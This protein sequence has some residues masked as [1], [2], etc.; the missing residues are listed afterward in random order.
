MDLRLENNLGSSAVPESSRD[1]VSIEV[2]SDE[3]MTSHWFYLK[4]VVCIAL[5]KDF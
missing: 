2:D 5:H 4:I 3:Q 1:S